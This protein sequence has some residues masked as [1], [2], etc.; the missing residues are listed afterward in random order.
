MSTKRDKRRKASN[1]VRGS[2]E[3]NEA[4]LLEATRPRTEE[5]MQGIREKMARSWYERFS[6]RSRGHAGKL[7]FEFSGVL[8][9]FDEEN[10]SRGLV[11]R[12]EDAIAMMSPTLH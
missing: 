4:K 11:E 12:T 7:A 8:V 9:P 6:Y 5:E 1:G 2:K 10:P 3:R